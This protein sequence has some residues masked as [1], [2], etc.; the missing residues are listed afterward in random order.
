MEA[1]LGW[2]GVTGDIGALIAA[3]AAVAAFVI[4]YGDL[5]RWRQEA[6]ARALSREVE[7]ATLIRSLR[8][9]LQ[10]RK[11]TGQEVTD[12]VETFYRYAREERL[13]LAN[14]T[15]RGASIPGVS[16]LGFRLKG[17]ARP[18]TFS[19]CDLTLA[20]LSGANAS[21]H[22][23]AADC[24]R[25]EPIQG[26][27]YFNRCTLQQAW[28][29]PSRG[30]LQFMNCDLTGATFEDDLLDG[31]GS[32]HIIRSDITDADFGQLKPSEMEFDEVS[33]APGREPNWPPGLQAVPEN[34]TGQKRIIARRVLRGSPIHFAASA[35][36]RFPT[37]AFDRRKPLSAY[38]NRRSPSGLLTPNIMPEDFGL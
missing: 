20:S 23:T 1:V 32:I 18:A 13:D 2:L 19:T 36:N 5:R 4:A 21:L 7:R 25:F 11:K 34:S 30:K 9:D 26:A 6:P 8:D 3:V 15:I 17:N 10:Y 28:F 38:K 22:E 37:A 33:W 27:W 31:V 12:L 16:L 24:A 14:A 29:A 35:G